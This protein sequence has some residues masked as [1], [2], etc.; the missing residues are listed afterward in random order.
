VITL[1]A[2]LAHPINPTKVLFDTGLSNSK[3][4]YLSSLTTPSLSDSLSQTL[5][6]LTLLLKSQLMSH[7]MSQPTII[8]RPACG[9][10]VASQ[11]DMTQSCQLICYWNDLEFLLNRVG[12]VDVEEREEAV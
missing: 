12:V 4:I 7:T 10:Q 8:P 5:K 1:S 3:L 2:V 6:L 9:N 11:F